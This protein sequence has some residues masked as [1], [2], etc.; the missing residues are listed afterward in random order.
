MV[1][2]HHIR[3]CVRKKHNKCKLIFLKRFTISNENSSFPKKSYFN[4]VIVCYGMGFVQL[5][6][7]AQ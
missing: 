4:V 2:F 6:M 1:I 3:D 7:C 5:N